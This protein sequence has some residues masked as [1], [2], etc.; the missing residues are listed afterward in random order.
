METLFFDLRY[1]FRSL[2]RQPSFALTAILTLA[3]G[4]GGSTAMF[5][6]VNAVLLRPLPFPEP[7]RIV[8]VTNFWLK[9][10]TRG[11]NVSWQDFGDWKERNQSFAALGRFSGWETSVTV[12]GAGMYATVY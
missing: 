9:T 2:F 3:L 5:G 6:V 11:Q 1:A 7:D 4:I 10:G 8:A 12:Q